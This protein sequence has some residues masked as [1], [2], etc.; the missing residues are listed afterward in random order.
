MLSLILLLLAPVVSQRTF[1][2]PIAVTV[3]G[4]TV[5][6]TGNTI[7]C[8]NDTLLIDD[9]LKLSGSLEALFGD[10]TNSLATPKARSTSSR[11][12]TRHTSPSSQTSTSTTMTLKILTRVPAIP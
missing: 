5:Y 2:V 3:A 7:Y 10:F 11:F 12:S 1:T 6:M 8:N 9:N 4:D